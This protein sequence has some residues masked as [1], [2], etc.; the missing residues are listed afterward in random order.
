[1]ME[2]LLSLAGP[3]D[4]ARIEAL[5]PRGKRDLVFLA[6]LM[7]GQ[8]GWLADNLKWIVKNSNGDVIASWLLQYIFD[9][10]G[11][12]RPL[13]D[14]VWQGCL[15]DYCGRRDEIVDEWRKLQHED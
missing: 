10:M 3:S 8:S 2:Q 6:S 14:S 11:Y 4:R 15:A 1:M 13:D 7:E 5:P 9:P 12:A